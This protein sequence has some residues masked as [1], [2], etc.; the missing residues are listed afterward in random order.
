MCGLVGSAGE[1]LFTR[2]AFE[3][4]VDLISHRGP[5]GRGVFADVDVILGHRRLAVAVQ[6][7]S[8]AWNPR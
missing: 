7:F 6:R 3:N 1:R 8:Q 2:D 4:A 5:D